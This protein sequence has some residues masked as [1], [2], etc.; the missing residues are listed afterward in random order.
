MLRKL[1]G[2]LAIAAMLVASGGVH[3][4]LAFIKTK[5]MSTLGK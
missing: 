3:A 1:L 5:V 4:E 2:K